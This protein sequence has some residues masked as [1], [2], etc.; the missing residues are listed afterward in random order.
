MTISCVF[1][2]PKDKGVTFTFHFI[3][4]AQTHER[5]SFLFMCVEGSFKMRTKTLETDQARIHR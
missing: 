2:I 5:A 1:I 3:T 4:V